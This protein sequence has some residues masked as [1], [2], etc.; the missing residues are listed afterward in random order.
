VV[1]GAK[2]QGTRVI[3]SGVHAQP[4]VAL[5]RSDL[6]DEIGDGNLCGTLPEALDRAREVTAA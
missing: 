6:L 4:M 1:R 2:K 3:L 5:G